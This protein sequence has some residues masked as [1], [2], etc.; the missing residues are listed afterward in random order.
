MTVENINVEAALKKVQDLV[1]AEKDLSPTLKVALEVLLF[2]VTILANR[3]GL[4]SKNSSKPPA[5]DPNRKKTLKEQGA[6]KPGGQQCHI[7][8][9]LKPVAEPDLVKEITIDRSTLPKG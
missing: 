1:A 3:L 2:L 4:N 6:R 8:S 7:G 9:T 5:S